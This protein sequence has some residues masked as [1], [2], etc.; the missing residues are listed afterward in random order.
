[1]R[2]IGILAIRAV[3][4][5]GI[6]VAALSASARAE[7]VTLKN[8]STLTGRIT[9]RDDNFTFL[10]LSIGGEITLDN[11]DIVSISD[12][13]GNLNV[14]FTPIPRKTED[15]VSTPAP[16]AIVVIR[17]TPT[18]T[19]TPLP[20]PT[21]TP[22]KLRPIKFRRVDKQ[23]HRTLL[24]RR[25]VYH[26]VVE[27]PIED[28]E[29]RLLLAKLMKLCLQDAKYADAIEIRLYGLDERGKT[30]DW[31]FANG[32][33]APEG[34]WEKADASIP[35]SQ[36]LLKVVIQGEAEFYRM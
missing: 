15:T 27:E 2:R 33:Y 14:V 6:A 36:F 12:T 3:C 20:T 1:M 32:V 18:P 9:H 21:P 5:L 10:E 13:E 29:T 17:D 24:A 16:D 23:E 7:I 30:F 28:W 22:L 31:P 26:I 35:R 4:V 8:G 19:M 11:G 34:D 25:Y